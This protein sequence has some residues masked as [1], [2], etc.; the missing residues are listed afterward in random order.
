MRIIQE[1]SKSDCGVD[2]QARDMRRG[3]FNSRMM[4]M[5]ASKLAS[6]FC[7]SLSE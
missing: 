4:T 2:A 5:P 7:D 6:Q 1:H 3:L